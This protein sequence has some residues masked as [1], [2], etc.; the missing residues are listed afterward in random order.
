MNI[1]MSAFVL[2]PLMLFSHFWVFVQ[3]PPSGNE[4]PSSNTNWIDSFSVTLW[5][6]FGRTPL[7]LGSFM[8]DR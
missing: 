4:G 3:K 6:L 2:L 8:H 7:V 5:F 1:S